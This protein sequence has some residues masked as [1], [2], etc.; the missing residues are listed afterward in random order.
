MEGVSAFIV[1]TSLVHPK[2]YSDV[3]YSMQFHI[4]SG[5][6]QPNHHFRCGSSVEFYVE[7]INSCIDDID[8]LIC[9]VHE[10]AF[11]EDI[12][13]LPDDVSGFL[14]TINCSQIMPYPDYPGYVK[15]RRL[16]KMRYNWH[17]KK[18]EF[19]Q[20]CSPHSFYTYCHAHKK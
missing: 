19:Q 13:V 2:L 20:A 4:M 17:C 16:G 6:Q 1:G 18:F 9:N 14:D 12:P 10:M 15:L 3:F 5:D 11:T 7:P 8:T